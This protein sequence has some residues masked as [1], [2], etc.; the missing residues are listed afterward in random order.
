MK[1]KRSIFNNNYKK[2][3]LFMWIFVLFQVFFRQVEYPERQVSVFLLMN[4]L[5][6]FQFFQTAHF[7]T[8]CNEAAKVKQNI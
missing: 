6:N 1:V 8:V 7:F 4:I 3:I 2:M 5:F